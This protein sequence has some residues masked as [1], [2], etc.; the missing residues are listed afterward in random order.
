MLITMPLAAS[1]RVKVAPG[2]DQ[3]WQQPNGRRTADKRPCQQR[4]LRSAVRLRGLGHDLDDLL[5]V[6]PGPRVTIERNDARVAAG[7]SCEVDRLAGEGRELELFDVEAG[8]LRQR[9][10]RVLG[11]KRRRLTAPAAQRLL[12]GG[13][14][15]VIPDYTCYPAAGY[16]Q[17]TQEVA[18]ALAW[19]LENIERYGGDAKR[20]IVAA[21]SAGGQ[22]AALAVLDPQW[23]AAHGHSAAELLKAA[24]KVEMVHVPYRGS[25]QALSPDVGEPGV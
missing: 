10:A 18:A 17:Q 16:P 20:V 9:L 24:T 7:E 13:L 8:D 1:A 11:R 12:S 14:V 2:E 15:L 25:P 19:T 23:L 4:D 5:A 21:Q 3:S 22:I 6:E